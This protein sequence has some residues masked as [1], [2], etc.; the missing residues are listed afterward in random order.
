MLV[1]EHGKKKGR[2]IL[3]IKGELDGSSVF[4]LGTF[5]GE[6]VNSRTAHLTLD[7]SQVSGFEYT[8]VA[9]SVAVL[10]F[11]A[12]DF[13]KITCCG[14]PRNIA[15][16]LK[17]LDVEKIPNIEIVARRCVFVQ[18]ETIRSSIKLN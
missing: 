5:L 2:P 11:Y 3:R 9:L 4:Q 1:A 17:G 12:R 16:I 14:L 18:K 8:G 13:S 6:G 7:F 10:E 15:H